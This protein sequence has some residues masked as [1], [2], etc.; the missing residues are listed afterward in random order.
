MSPLVWKLV[1][2]AV[3]WVVLALC[4][5]AVCWLGSGEPKEADHDAH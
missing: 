1:A 4:Y 5:L 2:I 3:V